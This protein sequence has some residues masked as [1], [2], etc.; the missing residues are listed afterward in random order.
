[1]RKM[2]ICA[3]ALVLW[4]L[5]ACTFLSMRIEDQMIP[6]VKYF[7]GGEDLDID[8][9]FWDEQGA[10][11]FYTW[12]GSTSLEDDEVEE[13][14]SS[15]YSIEYVEENG[16]IFP[17]LKGGAGY[18]LNIIQYA[19]KIP[20]AGGRIKEVQTQ[21]YQDDTW[22]MVNTNPDPELGEIILPQEFARGIELSES[23]GSAAVFS[24]KSQP[25]PFMPD[26]AYSAIYSLDKVLSRQIPDQNVEVF[27]LTD[28]RTFL[29]EM[30]KV[31]L[32]CAIV[33]FVLVISGFSFALAGGHR[34]NKF[35]LCVNGGLGVLLLLGFIIL[36][37]A[38]SLPSSLLPADVILSFKHYSEE[39]SVIR[40]ALE[41]FASAPEAADVL[42][43]ISSTSVLGVLVS[44]AGGILA[45]VLGTLELL[46]PN[47]EK[48]K[49]SHAIACKTDENK[50][51]SQDR[52]KANRE[53]SSS[54]ADG[55]EQR[56]PQVKYVPRHFKK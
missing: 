52:K 48:E 35:S 26:M 32:L 3:A 37:M 9:L 30:L 34:E 11:F 53:L 20:V 29:S 23:A 5:I 33:V 43:Q 42:S 22:L 1:M 8:V 55:V 36:T 45:A 24:V 50:K 12:G 7:S 51:I 56:P 46:L 2:V 28:V 19:T 21:E 17:V 44:I 40:T 14:D 47:R 25:Q 39:F 16:E 18:G 13:Q 15:Q 27:S 10:H 31:A 49:L 54:F 4:L 6:A 38:I 41:S